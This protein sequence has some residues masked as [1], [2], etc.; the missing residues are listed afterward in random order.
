VARDPLAVRSSINF[1]GGSITAPQGTLQAIFGTE[2]PTLQFNETKTVQRDQHPRVRVIG[3]PT[4]QVRATSYVTSAVPYRNSNSVGGGEPVKFLVNGEWWTVRLS[5][6]H[7]D[8]NN[9][10]TNAEWANGENAYWRSERNTEYGPFAASG[11]TPVEPLP[12]N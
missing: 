3:G 2:T 10:L 8:L 9:F 7:Q 1:P 6:T 11:G 4:T 12:S 5:G